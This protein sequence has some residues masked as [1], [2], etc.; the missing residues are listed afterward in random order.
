MASGVEATGHDGQTEPLITVVIPTYNE[1]K[2]ILGALRSLERQSLPRGMY[3]II[4]VD[5]YS[6]DRTV[7]LAKGHADK[8]IQQKSDRV[9]GARNDGVAVARG[10]IIATTDADCVLPANWLE[11]I[12]DD[13]K[14]NDIVCLYGP[15][16]P[17]ENG[18]KYT[19]WIE[20]NNLF[21]RLLY[22]L[23]LLYMAVGANTAFRKKEFMMVGGYPVVTAGDDYGLPLRFKRR[24]FK[25]FFDKSLFVFF[26]MRRYQKFGLLRSYYQWLS[27][28]INELKKKKVFPTRTYHR[29]RY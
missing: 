17:L 3:E 2:F 20:L 28:V 19:M 21:A 5:G 29:Q 26:S 4:I 16:K 25:V 10:D 11:K 6:Q 14:K 15:T 13:F 27:N 1:E 24:G 22:K 9:A 7:E 8:I 12:L 23:R 18:F